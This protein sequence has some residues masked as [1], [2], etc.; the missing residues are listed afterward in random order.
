MAESL[1][2]AVYRGA[3]IGHR[4]VADDI[5]VPVLGDVGQNR[6]IGALE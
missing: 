6:Q 2:L 3:V 4:A 1:D 5:H